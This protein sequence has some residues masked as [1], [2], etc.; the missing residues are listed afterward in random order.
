MR[1][2]IIAANWKMNTLPKEGVE[3]AKKINN[4]LSGVEL[5]LNKKV[6]LGVP[7]THISKIMEVVDYKKIA[8]AAQNCSQYDFGAY[9]GEISAEM[10]KS[11][12]VQYVILGHSERRLY[13]GETDEIIAQ[14]LQQAYKNAIFPIFC[15]GETLQQRE[16]GNHFNVVETQL[17]NAFVKV[18]KFNFQRT[19][20]AYEPVWAIGTGQNAT[21]EQAQ[22]MHVFIRKIISNFYGH[23][24]ANDISILYGGSVIANNARQIFK[25][26]HIDG[27]LVGGASL[28]PDE[29]IQ[30]I[31]SA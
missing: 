12:G 18:D 29:F 1:K 23:E 25:C 13:F 28:K 8:I 9:T 6:V 7:F 14:K 26:E 15:C 21:P 30:I 22:E 24:I 3:I 20:I 19:V 10:L 27:G 5:G 2:T 16:K 31:E 4:Y 17:I 11:L